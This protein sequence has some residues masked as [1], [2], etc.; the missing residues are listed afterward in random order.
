VA[1]FILSIG[2]AVDANILV[3]ERT[4]EELR[5][6]RTLMSAVQVGFNRAWSAIRDGNV[7]TMITCAILF[8]FGQRLGTSVIQGFALTLFIGVAV[9]MIS[10]TVVTRTLLLITIISPLGRLKGLFTPE[11][12]HL[13]GKISTI[14]SAKQGETL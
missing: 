13:T 7:S 14:D 8:W 6:G 9:S 5:L 1:A 10:A 11:G 2:L 4:K 3:F 12:F